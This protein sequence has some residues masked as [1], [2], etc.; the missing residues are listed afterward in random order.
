METSS[1]L[2]ASAIDPTLVAR[3]AKGEVHA[4]NQLYDQS[5]TVLFSL[6]L[7]ILGNREEAADVLQEIYLNVWR[8][9]VRYD[10]GRGTPIAWLITLTRNRAIDRL[11]A[12]GPRTLRQMASS[13]DDGQ[14]SQVA[15][16]SSDT[17][18]T[19]ADQELRNLVRE[20]WVSLPHVQQQV[21][22]LAYYEGFPDAEIAAQLNQPVEAVKTCIALGMSQLLESL[23]SSWEEDE[24]V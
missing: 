8:K 16:R 17:F 6:A 10:V 21:I 1:Q 7:R 2:V 13:L 20:A 18:D 24:A 19:P 22:E 11:R 14:T 23:Q 9:V 3:V 4:F 12:R 15:D 5:S